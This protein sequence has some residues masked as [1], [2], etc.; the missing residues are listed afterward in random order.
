MPVQ[1][2]GLFGGAQ[3]GYN[4][5]IGPWLL[6]LELD[7]QASD[8]DDK[9]TCLFACGPSGIIIDERL[10]WFGTTRARFGWA[11]GSVVSYI[12]GGVAY[13]KVSTSSNFVSNLGPGPFA[14]ASVTSTRVGW[15]AGSGVE[16]A[17]GGPWSLKAEYLFI[18]L[19]KTS[20]TYTT[21]I[22]FAPGANYFD[23]K[24][25]AHLFRAGLNYRFGA[26]A[27]P[28]LSSFDWSGFYLGANAGYGI[29]RDPTWRQAEIIGTL[30]IF[31]IGPR[32]I[33]SGVQAGYNWQFANAIFG[34]EAD[35]QGSLQKDD[36]VCVEFCS[37][38]SLML[39]QR[40][41]W[42]GT[43]RGR[44]GVTAGDAMIYTT[45]GVA[46]GQF[47]TEATLDVGI[48]TAT[49]TFRHTKIGWTVGAGIERPLALLGPNWTA[50]TE[51]LYVDLGSATDVITVAGLPLSSVYINTRIHD[52]I[53]RTGVNF[54]FGGP[55]RY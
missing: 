14:I 40:L 26:P 21:F 8:L 38:S 6:G 46:Y 12:T 23:T 3:A 22:A 15:T 44:I 43:A 30:E 33:L 54:N 36:Y 39:D 28:L 24:Y 29:A 18:D 45:A 37:T 31:E 20:T 49:D 16:V 9:K 41:K 19:G 25:Q 35:F 4:W 1:P 7:I 53:W 13:G 55:A 11:S 27:A 51:Y 42:F 52:H 17:L 48:G 50:K 47:T 34:I 32:G 2:N 10:N 5:Q